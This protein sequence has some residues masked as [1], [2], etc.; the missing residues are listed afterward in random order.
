MMLSKKIWIIDDDKSIRWVI[1]KTLTQS[2]YDSLQF[3]NAN[4]AINEFNRSEPILIISDISMPGESGLELLKK[5]T[6]KFPYIP[7]II[8]TAFADLQSTIDAYKF[9]AFEFLT[10]PFEIENLLDLIKKALKEKNIQSTQFE[11]PISNTSLLGNSESMQAV[12]KSIGKLSRS[13]ASILITGE[14]GTGK[15]LVAKLI[16]NNSSRT[17]NPF[18][19]INAAAIPDDLLESELFGYEKGA[20]TGAS[21]SKEGFFESAYGGTLFLDEIGDMPI[22]LQAK[23][24]R[25]LND[26][27]FQKVGSNKDIRSNVRILAATH[28]DLD[29]MIKKNEFRE[30]LYHRLN[31]I[32]IHLPPLRDRPDD[33]PQ[34]S[35]H[36][37]RSS[38]VE[39]G[40][41]PKF[42]N[43]ETLNYFK[44]LQWK[45]NVRQ[46]R[47]ICHWLT[48]MVTGNEIGVSD[49][50]A[51]LI[52]E[53]I[54]RPASSD[55]LN[56]LKI[57]IQ[58][59]IQSGSKDLYNKYVELI[60]N[61]LLETALAESNNKKIQAAKI[62]GI[63]R[64]TF[65]RK[66]KL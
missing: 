34:L 41:S 12:Y 63:G 65:S 52:N 58:N 1:D 17:E 39:L 30:D 2:G 56:I 27:V 21:S 35:E 23:I 59:D 20:F 24:L 57:N 45:G 44:R 54:N 49:L 50:P 19:V 48:V 51:E 10:K 46:L 29:D 15:E 66:F 26:G 32:N 28:K 22:N 43:P 14:S 60:E 16:H 61:V 6:K 62:L 11:K 3:S 53:N 64:N 9:G 47:N 37:L 7:I 38:S 42:L 33:I 40:V 18:I 4:D 55:W 5:V 25:V 31:V 8:I 36:F 13:N